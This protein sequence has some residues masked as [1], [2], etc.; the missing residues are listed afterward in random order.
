[1]KYT[2]EMTSN[3]MIHVQNFMKICSGTQVLCLL[4]LQSE[5]M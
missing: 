3:D 5:R 4:S 1:M 2:V